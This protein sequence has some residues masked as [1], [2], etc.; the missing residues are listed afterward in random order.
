FVEFFSLFNN[1]LSGSV[2]YYKRTSDELLLY[3]PISVTTGFGNALVNLGVVENKGIEVELRT[4]NI[5]TENFRWATT[6]LLSKN[7]NELVDFADSNGQI[8]NV[9]SKRAAEWINLEGQPISSFYGWVVDRDIP[10]EFI[11]NPYFPI[12]AEAQDVYV[13]D[14]NGDGLIDDDD[15]TI[16]GNPYPD[17]IWSLSNE[18]RFKNVDLSFLLQ[19]SHGAEIRNMGDQYLFNQFNSNQDFISSTPDQG[20]I[21]QKIF[22]NDIIQDASYVALRNFNLGFSFTDGMLDTLGFFDSFRVYASGQNLFYW[23]AD[24]YTGFNPESI[25]DTSPTTYGYQRAGSPIFKTISL[26]LNIEF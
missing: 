24:G 9:D 4:R 1:F 10:L 25:N 26:G 14:L 18:V 22:T 7:E 13:K 6:L 17:L 5:S 16:I 11:K 15:K 2:D 19:G 23:T 21:R 8:Q 3:N 12:G 20:F